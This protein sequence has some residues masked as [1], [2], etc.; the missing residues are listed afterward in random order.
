MTGK[1]K[2]RFADIW[3][4]QV[5]HLLDRLEH[6]GKM[7]R[8]YVRDMEEAFSQGV[9]A[10]AAARAQERRLEREH[11]RQTA[12]AQRAVAEAEELLA[13]GDEVGARQALQRKIAA[14]RTLA[15]LEPEIEESRQTANQVQTQLEDLRL[16]LQQAKARQE[17]FSVRQRTS[18][19]TREVDFSNDADPLARFQRIELRVRDR[20]RSLARWEERIEES[21]IEAD[22]WHEVGPGLP[23]ENEAVERELKALRS[24]GNKA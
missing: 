20:E 23:Q 24:A 14:Q 5:N 6:P 10:V 11:K 16:R 15:E 18:A 9:A 22:I 17:Q 2:E 8:Q 1:S 4:S 3:R 21:E 7:V 19:H 12:R 13:A